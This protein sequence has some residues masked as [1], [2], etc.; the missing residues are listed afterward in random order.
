MSS[1][2]AAVRTECSE[3]IVPTRQSHLAVRKRVGSLHEP[4]VAPSPNSSALL[5]WPGSAG[6]SLALHHASEPFH[7]DHVAGVEAPSD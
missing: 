4:L 1:P 2:K 7:L 6:G 5:I 3:A